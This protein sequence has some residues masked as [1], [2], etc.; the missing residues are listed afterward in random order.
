[1]DSSRIEKKIILKATQE[2]V[3]SA[4]SD[5]ANFGAWFGVDIDDPFVAGKEASGRISPTKVDPDVAR[6]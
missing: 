3:W 5:S 6:L 4:I 1:M 2:R